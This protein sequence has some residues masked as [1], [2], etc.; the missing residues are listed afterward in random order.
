MPRDKWTRLAAADDM[1]TVQLDSLE[2]ACEIVKAVAS[3]GGDKVLANPKDSLAKILRSTY[4]EIEKIRSE[5]I[6]HK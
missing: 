4:D 1:K 3:S 6:G 5:I 2:V